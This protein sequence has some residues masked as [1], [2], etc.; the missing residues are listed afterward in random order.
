MD[1]PPPARV[2]M[3]AQ[4]DAARQM[5]ESSQVESARSLA[6]AVLKTAEDQADRSMQGQ[7]LMALAQYDRV[8]GRFR[9]AIETVQRAAQLFQLEGDIAAEASAL[10]LLAHASSFLGRDEEAVEAG[11]LSVKLGDLLPSGPQQVNLYNYL[12]VSYLWSK[13]F[14]DAE[15]ALRESERLA[16]IH[17]PESNVLLPRIN[18]AWLEAVR[19][20]KERYFHGALPGTQ[21]L[22]QRLALCTP[23]FDDDAPFPGLP[24]VRAVLQRFGRCA[25]A[26]AHC[27]RGDLESAETWLDAAQDPARPG[28]YA[29]VANYV[30]HWVRAEL[31]WARNDLPGAQQE[32]AI[33]IER[34]GEAEFEQMA[35][36]GHLLLIQIH[37]HHGQ[38]ALALREER[39]LRLR[40]LRVRA[41]SLDSRHRVVQAQLDIR[42][43]VRDL[44]LLATHAQELERLSF[45]DSL[46]GIANRRRFETQLSAALAGGQNP[47]HPTCVALIDIDDFKRVNDTH[48]HEAGDDVLRKVAEAIRDEVR[49]SD[50]PAR[51]GGDEFVVLFPYTALALARSV[52]ERIH[53]KVAALRWAQWSADLQMTVSIGV[54][55]SQPGDSAATLLQRSDKA[56]FQAKKKHA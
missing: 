3:L 1:A 24:G 34:A 35:Y 16:L 42:A 20:F 4:L 53:A 12:G 50:L 51:L 13:S 18:L 39:A 10:S 33:L 54:A 17:A 21:T 6:S 26:L 55:Q 7:A 8:L 31:R 27:W 56:M 43:S 46:T 45:E 38:L 48:S 28:N 2:A 5:L 49:D 14:A 52:C 30:V 25:Q 40:Q 19:L 37:S 47:Q 36:I 29:Q 41:D 11:L 44:R 15:T 22:Q 23:L 9:R 32:A